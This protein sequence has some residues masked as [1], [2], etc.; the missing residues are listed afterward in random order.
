MKIGIVGW[1]YVG[2][3]T[4]LGLRD[5]HEIYVYDP[6]KDVEDFSFN[7]IKE[8]PYKSSKNLKVIEDV[9]EL[10]DVDIIFLCL[11]TP[12]NNDGSAN[13]TY[14]DNF[15]SQL[16]KVLDDGTIVIRSTV[17]PGTT[18]NMQAKYPK[19]K[20]VHNPEFLREK[21]PLYDF[22]YPSRIVIGSNNKHA[23]EKV[24]EIYK[25]FEC[26]KI[27]TD[28][29]SSEM[30]KYTANCFLANKISYFNEIH[31]ICER[32]GADPKT[33]AE[34]VS[35]DERIGRYGIYGG[36]PFGGACLPKDLKALINH[37]ENKIGFEPDLLK[38]VKKINDKVEKNE[39]S[40]NGV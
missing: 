23:S 4:G 37:V 35:L 28:P 40:N 2:A 30:I 1:G 31:M 33:V 14:I 12:S 19:F 22:L 5:Q 18:V 29:M 21:S 24:L 36:R 38:S 17:P 26:M 13:T 34:A 32:V 16:N 8:L 7:I 15:L 9:E 3:S 25:P 39:S 11:P 27:V 10:K 6:F 20:F